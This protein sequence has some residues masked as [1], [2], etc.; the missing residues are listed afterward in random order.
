MNNTTELIEQ[1]KSSLSD[2][3]QYHCQLEEEAKAMGSET[4]AAIDAYLADF[5]QKKK[6]AK[7]K[8]TRLEKEISNI[9]KNIR[10]MYAS[11]S[12]KAMQDDFDGMKT[13]Q[14]EIKKQEAHR[15]NLEFQL[16]AIRNGNVEGDPVLAK[17][18]IDKYEAFMALKN[19]LDYCT[20][21]LCSFTYK[22]EDAFEYL[23][24]RRE[25]IT[26]GFIPKIESVINCA[27][28]AISEL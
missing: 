27:A 5:E 10:E 26:A 2:L 21:E 6:D 23:R 16:T 8:I 19:D 4:H 12:K 11:V 22:N 9:E 24:R 18:A 13:T 7:N 28:I 3:E 25:H 20:Q 14:A 17:T 1:V 15:S